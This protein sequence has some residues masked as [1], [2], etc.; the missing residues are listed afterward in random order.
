MQQGEKLLWA[1]AVGYVAYQIYQGS[2]SASGLMGIGQ[3]S[4]GNFASLFFKNDGTVSNTGG[5]RT[6][7]Q[8]NTGLPLGPASNWTTT[9]EYI[10]PDGT[11]PT[12]GPNASHPLVYVAP[13]AFGNN[14]QSGDNPAT[15]APTVFQLA[16]R[17]EYCGPGCYTY[18]DAAG[19]QI[20]QVGTAPNYA[21][22]GFGVSGVQ[23]GW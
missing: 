2:K 11:M 9:S 23:D 20:G 10:G 21:A 7:I 22:M 18:Y 16:A 15:P 12:T 1:A 13:I 19:N 17:T 4:N 8:Q 6:G 3:Q 14:Q 5:N